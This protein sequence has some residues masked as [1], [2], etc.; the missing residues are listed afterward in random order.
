MAEE[1][2]G[3]ANHAFAIVGNSVEQDDGGAAGMAGRDEPGA[4]RGSVLRGD[5]NV[6][7]GDVEFLCEGLAGASG[8]EQR[9][10]LR[11]ES[12]L[13]EDDAACHGNDGVEDGGDGEELQQPAKAD[14]HGGVVTQGGGPWFHRYFA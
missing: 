9:A 4:Q 2:G 1:E 6:V 7:D 11:M 12:E 8:V 13:G 10:A 14:A 3:V 5:G